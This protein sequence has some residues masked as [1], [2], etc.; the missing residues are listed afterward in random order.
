MTSNSVYRSRIIT[1]ARFAGKDGKKINME[2]A[3]ASVLQAEEAVGL[4]MQN[5]HA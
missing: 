1:L 2:A 4:M 5:L 3:A